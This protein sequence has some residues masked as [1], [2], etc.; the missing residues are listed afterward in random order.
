MYAYLFGTAS[1]AFL[2]S[3][4]FMAVQALMLAAGQPRGR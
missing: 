3:S 2:T 1:G 4:V